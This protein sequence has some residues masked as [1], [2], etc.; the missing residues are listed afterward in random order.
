[1]EKFNKSV[2]M[3]L[4]KDTEEK[5]II[6]GQLIT[7][8]VI[9]SYGD[10]F[11]KQALDKVNKD[12]TYF[13]LHMHEWSKELGT[14]KVYQDE[15]GNLK[16]T[17]KLDLS[18]DENGNAINKDAQKVY[19]MMK[20]GANYEMSV[21]GFLKQREWGKIQTDKGEVDAR[22][23]KEIDV[24]EG[25]VVLKGAVPDATVTTVKNDKGDE[26]MN[27]ENLEK[28][29]NK[30]TEEIEK[31]G[32]KLTELEEKANKIAELEEKLNKSSEEM[33]KMAGA[34][35]EVMRKG[36]E[37]PETVNKAQNEAFEKYLRTG[38]KS[39][40]GLEKAAIGTGQATV[41]IPTILSHEILKET[42]EVSNFLM[43][44]KVYQGSGDYIKIPV[45]N[46]ITPANQ[47]VKEGQGNTQDGALAYT[48]K[49]LRAGYRQVRYPIT[50]ELV[51]DSAFDMV[52]ELKEAISEEFGQTLSDLTVKGTYNASTEQY[53][54]G[55]LTNTAITGAA[56]TSATT[57]KVTADDLVKLETG[58]KASYRQGAAYFVSPKLYEEMKLWK[59]ADGRFLWANIIE[60]ATM[61]FN[62]YPV[63]VEEFLED[64]DTGKYPAVFCDFKKGYA[65]YLKK[66]FEQELHR[67]VNERTTEYYTR[68]RIGG[69]VIRPKAFSVLKVK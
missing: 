55:F 40:E 28:G 46:D 52:G 27:L 29:I 1:M 25:S 14:L 9:D 49:E 54:E 16:F 44:G 53:I 47:I 41:L 10:Y 43:Q 45:R 50:D 30:N 61:K 62:G 35:D 13:L 5:G 2:E 66:G 17:A 68:I 31:A 34:L 33:E 58:M 7:H 11:D 12:K 3:V 48:H 19:S 64:I 63:Y 4:K 51:Q 59:D 26:N 65:Y 21:G 23:I 38:D 18:T 20:S 15:K 6:E 56:I 67:N 32:Q 39:I 57:K 37:N 22:I 8:S 36:M 60:G 69:G 42:K 24:V